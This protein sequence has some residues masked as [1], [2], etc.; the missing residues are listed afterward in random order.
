M[1]HCYL[2]VMHV[3]S[4]YISLVKASHMAVSNMHGGGNVQSP[5]CSLCLE[6]EGANHL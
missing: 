1:K 2:N 4:V 6:E 3:T 5:T